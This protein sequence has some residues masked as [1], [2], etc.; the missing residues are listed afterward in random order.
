MWAFMQEMQL[1]TGRIMRR[2]HRHCQSV[3]GELSYKK[4]L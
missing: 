1:E 4:L 3:L 2:L